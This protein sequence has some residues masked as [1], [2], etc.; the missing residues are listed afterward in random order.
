MFSFEQALSVVVL[1]LAVLV[2]YI[3]ASLTYDEKR[4]YK[5]YFRA[6]IVPLILLAILFFFFNLV[7]ALAL[8]FIVVLMFSWAVFSRMHFSE[9]A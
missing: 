3:T 1:L 5:K 2:G 6:T 7:I 8:C 4:T 9:N